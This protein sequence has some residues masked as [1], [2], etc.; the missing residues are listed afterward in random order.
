[1]DGEHGA[2]GAGEGDKNKWAVLIW[3]FG[4]AGRLLPCCPLVS[5]FVTEAPNTATETQPYECDCVTIFLPA[6][7]DQSQTRGNRVVFIV[8]KVGLMV[9]KHQSL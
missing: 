9:S 8:C 3:A 2:V 1:M 4:T 7:S 6:I 5:V